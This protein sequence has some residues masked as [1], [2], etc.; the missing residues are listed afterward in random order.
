M[1]LAIADGIR[2]WSLSDVL[3]AFVIVVVCVGVVVIVVRNS[4]I[5]IPSWVYSIFWLVLLAVVAILAI[6]FVAS[7]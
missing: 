4:G 1:L 7:L 2:T 3:V 5:T 6:R